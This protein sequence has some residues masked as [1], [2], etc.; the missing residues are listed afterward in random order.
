MKYRQE[1]AEENLQQKLAGLGID[2]ISVIQ[3]QNDEYQE[4]DSYAKIQQ[5]CEKPSNN[6]CDCIFYEMQKY[7][8]NQVKHLQA[9]V[10]LLT[11]E[12]MMLKKVLLQGANKGIPAK[13]DQSS[14]LFGS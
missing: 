13:G 4:E 8:Q 10:N 2:D 6:R 11:E 5:S 9:R 14:I 3:P 1:G 7:H 12:N